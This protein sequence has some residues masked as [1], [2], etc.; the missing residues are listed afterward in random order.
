MKF[1]R[2][3]IILVVIGI[4]AGFSY[5]YFEVKKAKEKKEKEEK[6]ALLFEQKDSKINWI[7]IKRK[8]DE[9]PIIAVRK[10][11]KKKKIEDGKEKEIN[12]DYW[13]IKSPVNTNGDLYALDTMANDI[14]N[15]KRE[16][17]VWDSLEK[18]KDY[19]LDNPE[20]SVRFKYENDDKERGIDFGIKTLD[21]KKVFAKVVGKNKIY[22]VAAGVYDQ[23]NKSLFDVRDKTISPYG[24]E[25]IVSISLISA[26]NVFTLKKEKDGWYFTDGVKASDSRVELY[27]GHLRWGNFNEVVKERATLKDLPE[28][29]LD[30]PRLIIKYGL[31]NDKKDY[32]FLVGDPIKEGD[33]TYYYATRN[34][35]DMIFEV[36]SDLVVKLDTSK[37]LLKD[38][39]IFSFKYDDVN[40]VVLKN[41][42]KSFSF[43]KKDGD[44]YFEGTNKKV[45][46]GYKIDGIIRSL[47]DA[48]Y[49][50]FEPI[51][52][53]DPDYKKTGLDN[54][55]YEVVFYFKD[56]NE[57]PLRILVSKKNEKTQRV[58]ISPDNGE[59]AYY[60]FAYFVD[61]IPEKKKDLMGSD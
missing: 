40:K 18:A 27:E 7:K 44:W 13:E 52:R 61:N 5:W 36:T 47:E 28:Y 58:F 25:D 43:Y 46:K 35:D 4:L 33:V 16:E 34:T 14:K 10:T 30:K 60:T 20:L 1:F 23:L 9:K 32:I 17:V 8:D 6:E 26:H 2:N 49:E 56:E 38:R 37:F 53:G 45:E 19:G 11:K 31:K 54:P 55:K 3:A 57:K 21:G 22:A 41:G 15:A 29:G 39:H 50:E 48:E 12:V 42:D 59:T 24:K 51:K